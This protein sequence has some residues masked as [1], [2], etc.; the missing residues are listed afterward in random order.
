MSDSSKGDPRNNGSS[1][2][3]IM[4]VVIGKIVI[5][6]VVTVLIVTEVTVVIVTEVTVVIVTEVTVVIVT[7]VIVTVVIFTSISKNNLTPRHLCDVFRAAFCNL[8]MY[9]FFLWGGEFMY[10]I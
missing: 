4:S 5:V 1:D 8:P 3:S 7:V 9:F 2:I 6:T 10:G